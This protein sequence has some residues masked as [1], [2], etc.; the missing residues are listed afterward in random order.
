M[1]ASF[2][3]KKNHQIDLNF[4]NNTMNFINNHDN[5][6]V[7]EDNGD[8]YYCSSVMLRHLFVISTTNTIKE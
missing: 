5:D 4:F 7:H 3:E 1:G 2:H 6:K 8:Y